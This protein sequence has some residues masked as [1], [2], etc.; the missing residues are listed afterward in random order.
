MANPSFM[1]NW[2]V[3]AKQATEIQ[4]T[5]VAQFTQRGNNIGRVVMNACNNSVFKSPLLYSVIHFISE[6][7]SCMPAWQAFCEQDG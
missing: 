5:L 7:V 6:V 2:S 1:A 4:F 3:C